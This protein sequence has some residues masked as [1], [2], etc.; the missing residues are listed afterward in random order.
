MQNNKLT[1]QSKGLCINDKFSAS[2]SASIGNAQMCL[3]EVKCYDNNNLNCLI[4]K[5]IKA[6]LMPTHIQELDIID[7][8]PSRG[9]ISKNH[10]KL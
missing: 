9:R 5:Q 4:S 8:S 7:K 10:P 2:L 1:L 3:F 6:W